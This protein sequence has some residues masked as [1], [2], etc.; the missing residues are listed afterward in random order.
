MD[1]IHSRG[2]NQSIE[3]SSQRPPHDYN[4]QYWARASNAELASAA[5]AYFREKVNRA[6]SN[7]GYIRFGNHGSKAVALING[8]RGA[9][10]DHEGGFGGYIPAPGYEYTHSPDYRAFMDYLADFKYLDSEGNEIDFPE[11]DPNQPKKDTNKVAGMI[12]GKASA[13]TGTAG[14]LY[15]K[16]RG[17]TLD[18]DTTETL[19]FDIDRRDAND[20][21]MM[22]IASART[23]A[24]PGE[25]GKLVAIQRIYVT[26]DGKKDRDANDNAKLSLGKMKDEDGTPAFWIWRGSPE[27]FITEGVEDA[28]SVRLA[29]TIAGLEPPTVVAT[30]GSGRL[31]TAAEVFQGV[32]FVADNDKI[33]KATEAAR[34]AKGK[35]VTF[36]SYDGCNDANEVLQAHGADILLMALEKAASVR[37]EEAGEK[38]KD[39]DRFAWITRQNGTTPVLNGNWLVKNTVPAEGLGVMFGRPGS[40][41]T[42]TA[43]DIALHIARGLPWRGIKTRQKAVSYLSPEAGRMGANRVI[44]WYEHHG[45]EWPDNFRLSPVGI[46]LYS[47]TNDADALIAD[48]KANQPDCGLV[49]IDTLNRAMPGGDENSGQD[50]GMFVKLCD[51]I[52]FALKAFVMVVHH[53]GKDAA[54][55]SRGHSS[56]LGAISMELEVIREQ[57]EPGTIH[58]SK[59]RDGPDGQEFGFT[60]VS[61]SLGVDEDGEEVTTAIAVPSDV[62][63]AKAVKAAQPTGKN[64]KILADAFAQLVHEYGKPNPGGTGFPDPGRVMTL[65]AD[66]LIDFAIGKMVGTS[67]SEKR[68]NAREAIRSLAEKRYFAVNGGLIWRLK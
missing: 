56:L 35:L 16:K 51:S 5:S 24:G 43:I 19:R 37:E 14:E 63:A 36:S 6:A 40:G 3:G 26:E 58:V 18:A 65:E 46:D 54:K 20:H 11:T 25:K 23:W 38:A 52:A 61:R 42:F 55:G 33:D 28:L 67:D 59:L 4:E 17:L 27:V 2:E 34:I 31:K 32:T 21:R 48:I 49:I 12:W 66:R 45:E 8:A 47:S 9:F 50:M 53:S 15:L 62:E 30:L 7:D 39:G 10:F 13:I 64:Q 60:L 44:G 29:H 1:S 57:G 41:K 22:I 68:K